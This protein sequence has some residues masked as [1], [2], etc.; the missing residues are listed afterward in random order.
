MYWFRK[1]RLS[2]KLKGKMLLDMIFSR[3]CIVTKAYLPSF[4]FYLF[5][6]CFQN[7]IVS[8]ILK[9]SYFLIRQ[10][11]TFCH[12]FGNGGAKGSKVYMKQLWVLLYSCFVLT[13]FLSHPPPLIYTQH[14]FFLHHHNRCFYCWVCCDNE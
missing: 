1:S 9:P 10:T 7:K 14:Y 3:I 5:K 12:S 6:S 4:L 11:I 2:C 13:S 8:W